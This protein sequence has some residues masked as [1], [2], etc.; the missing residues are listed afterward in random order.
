MKIKLNKRILQIPIGTVPVDATDIEIDDLEGSAELFTD[1]GESEMSDESL[2][3]PRVS[4]EVAIPV[5]PEPVPLPMRNVPPVGPV[6]TCKKTHTTIFRARGFHKRCLTVREIGQTGRKE[7]GLALCS[8]RNIPYQLFVVSATIYTRNSLVWEE[9][10]RNSVSNPFA[11]NVPR[12]SWCF[13]PRLPTNELVICGTQTVTIGV[14]P[15]TIVAGGGHISRRAVQ[16]HVGG[17]CLTVTR[18]AFATFAVG[19]KKCEQDSALSGA[20]WFPEWLFADV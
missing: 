19:F 16:F 2:Q 6:P 14:K 8:D 9:P 1:S 10:V 15:L 7:L 11:N 5:M 17:L 12:K 20:D 13:D 4:T 3:I 18:I